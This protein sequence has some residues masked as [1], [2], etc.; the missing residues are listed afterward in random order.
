MR[1]TS[2]TGVG[3][4]KGI[5]TFLNFLHQRNVLKTDEVIRIRLVLYVLKAF[6]RGRGGVLIRGVNAFQPRSFEVKLFEACQQNKLT[7]SAKYRN[8][9]DEGVF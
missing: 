7:G 1:L 4:E 5:A 2:D 6:L 9:I 3:E 8:G